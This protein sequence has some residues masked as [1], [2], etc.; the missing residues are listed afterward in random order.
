ML[1]LNIKIADF[2][3]QNKTFINYLYPIFAK[4]D[5]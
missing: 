4:Y 2:L 5:F 3:F 1:L